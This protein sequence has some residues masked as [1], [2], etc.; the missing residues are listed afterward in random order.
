MK[1]VLIFLVLVMACSFGYADD[2]NTRQSEFI[3]GLKESAEDMI[4]AYGKLKQL[5]ESF[6]EEFS[7]GQDNDLSLSTLEDALSA[8][9]LDYTA[10]Q[11]AIN[12]G[13]DNYINFFEGSAVTTREYGKD[14]RRVADQQDL[15]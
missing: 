6:D 13:V 14:L 2:L 7:T 3:R 11:T 8:Q 10:I 5:G 4:K 15:Y 12:Q 1:K 9:G